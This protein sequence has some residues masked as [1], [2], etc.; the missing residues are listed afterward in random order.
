M[1]SE[2]ASEAQNRML[3]S[4]ASIAPGIATTTP[5]STS[6]ITAID[7]VSAARAIRSEIGRAHV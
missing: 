3:V 2:S 6:S 1:A 4:P 7:T 5:L